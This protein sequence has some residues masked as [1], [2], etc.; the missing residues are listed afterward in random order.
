MFVA[1]SQRTHHETRY[2]ETRDCLDQRWTSLLA[3]FGAVAV[4]VPNTMRDPSLL[5]NRLRPDAF[6]LTGGADPLPGPGDACGRNIVES[7][8]LAYASANG[9]PVVAICR[10]MQSLNVRL[11]GR[12]TA[13]AGHVAHSHLVSALSGQS[14]LVN[15]FHEFGIVGP[16]LADHL[17]PLL[18]AEDGS[19]EAVRHRDLPWTGLMWHPERHNANSL[20]QREILAAAIQGASILDVLS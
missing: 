15:S 6:V 11:G 10:G 3:E 7:E 16:D 8:I 20:L 17:Q 9:V 18:F 13:V 1:L 4:P 5:L 12:V 2:D 14:L 19:V